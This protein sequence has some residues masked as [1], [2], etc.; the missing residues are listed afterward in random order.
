MSSEVLDTEVIVKRSKSNLA[1]ALT[2]LSSERKRDMLSFYAFCRVVDDIADDDGIPK[3][4]RLEGLQRWREGIQFGFTNPNALER[5]IA[6]ILQRYQIDP[7]LMIEVIDGV[8][9]DLDEPEFET[10]E[11]LLA[12]CYKVA[13]AVGLV[14]IEIFGYTD[15]TSQEY[16]VKLGYALQL[17]NIIRDVGEDA[18]RGR[19]YLP[20][21]DLRKFGVERQQVLGK[22]S[23]ESL[24][25]LLAFEAERAEAFYQEAE[26]VLPR[27][28]QRSMLAARMMGQVYREILGKIKACDYE[29]L[30]ERIGLSKFR[31]IQIL[32]SYMVRGWLS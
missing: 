30:Q 25:K 3:E 2:T 20:N 14:S 29:V 7:S 18:E 1:F 11:D 23:S 13:S 5:E 28:D 8:A 32:M 22:E 31:K 4:Q 21:E 19:I 9:S 16:A 27:V 24:K 17:T 26:R 6:S 15:K 10:Y 12:Y